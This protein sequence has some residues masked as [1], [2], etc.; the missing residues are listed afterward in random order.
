MPWS[1]NTRVVK[2]NQTESYAETVLEKAK[3]R[4][5]NW[6]KFGA[7]T[8]IAPLPA[9]PTQTQDEYGEDIE[10]PPL[11]QGEDERR[12]GWR[13]EKLSLLITDDIYETDGQWVELE[14]EETQVRLDLADMI[15]ADLA[16]EIAELLN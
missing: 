14:A 5:M 4:V 13:Q 10:Q 8:K 15:L 6:A 11:A 2:T 1:K 3:F 16:A 12:N 7:G 9:A